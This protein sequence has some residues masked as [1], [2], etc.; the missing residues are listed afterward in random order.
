MLLHRDE[1]IAATRR[2]GVPAPT[3]LAHQ[4]TL[5]DKYMDQL[6]ERQQIDCDICPSIDDIG[7]SCERALYCPCRPMLSTF[8]ANSQLGYLGFIVYNSCQCGSVH[9]FSTQIQHRSNSKIPFLRGSDLLPPSIEEQHFTI[10]TEA[11]PIAITR[12][13]NR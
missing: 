8:A 1:C 10:L 6:A 13:S 9:K 7:S 5:Q 3:C 4:Q 12:V 11:N 2:N